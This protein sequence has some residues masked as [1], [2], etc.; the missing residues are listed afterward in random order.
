MTGDNQTGT[1]KPIACSVY[2]VLE[3]SSVKRQLLR[4]DIRSS[5]GII[6]RNVYVLDLFSQDKTEFL[7]GKDSSTD[8]E[9]A[10]RLDEIL[11]IT[12]PATNTVYSP[13]TC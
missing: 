10:V 1:Y 5:N 7:K 2:D 3:A 9:F 8:E 4:L 12:D 6:V 11:L 13:R